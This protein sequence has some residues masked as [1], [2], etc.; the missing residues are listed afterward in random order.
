MIIVMIGI[1]K[2]IADEAGMVATVNFHIPYYILLISL[3]LPPYEVS[4]FALR[5]KSHKYYF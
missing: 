5:G 1:D 3:V 2:K 4:F